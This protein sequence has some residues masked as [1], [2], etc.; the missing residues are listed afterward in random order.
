MQRAQAWLASTVLHATLLVAL[1]ATIGFMISAAPRT[2]RAQDPG[3]DVL[4]KSAGGTVAPE[5]Q[6]SAM[7]RLAQLAASGQLQLAIAR[8]R[9]RTVGVLAPS[10]TSEEEGGDGP[11]G[12]QAELSIA[13]DATGQHITRIV[14][15]LV[16]INC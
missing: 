4:A 10:D 16:G 6:M 11:A 5:D 15:A 13:V 14:Q 7:G 1:L 3:S 8:A 12:G 9:A 2:A